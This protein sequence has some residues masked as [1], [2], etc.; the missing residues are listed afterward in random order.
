M[1]PF[2]YSFSKKIN[3]NLNTALG[4]LMSDKYLKKAKPQVKERRKFQRLGY[5]LNVAVEYSAD[6][7]Y[8]IEQTRL[9]DIGRGGACFEISSELAIG[10]PVNINLLRYND[11]I[12]EELGIPSTSMPGLL[13]VRIKGEVVRSEQRP[14]TSQ[15]RR[16]ALR[17][18]T[19]LGLSI[20]LLPMDSDFSAHSRRWQYRIS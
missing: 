15:S 1:G 10:M 8:Q 2:W 18:D 14:N 17:F 7:Y 16:I 13:D 11:Q 9:M 12:A 5:P 6:G 20:K 4:E 3:G 19:P